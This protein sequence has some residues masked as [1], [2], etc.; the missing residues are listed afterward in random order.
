MLSSFVAWVMGALNS[1]DVGGAVW[2]CAFCTV[3][4]K[5]YSELGSA[6][7]TSA[8]ETSADET[9]ADETSANEKKKEIECLPPLKIKQN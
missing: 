9:S 7:E 2:V 3:V 8:D 6:D 4:S 1:E 5:R